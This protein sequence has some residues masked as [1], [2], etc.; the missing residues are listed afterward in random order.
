MWLQRFH[1]DTS[2]DEKIHFSDSVLA[3]SLADG[4][5]GYHLAR[6]T[7]DLDWEKGFHVPK[8]QS[9]QDALRHVIHLSAITR[10]FRKTLDVHGDFFHV[11][12]PSMTTLVCSDGLNDG[13][14]DLDRIYW[15]KRFQEAW[16]KTD[17]F[18]LLVQHG[19]GDIVAGPNRPTA[20][21]HTYTVAQK[22][23]LLQLGSLLYSHFDALCKLFDYEAVE[24]PLTHL[25]DRLSML[26][27]L[28][29]LKK[30]NVPHPT[31]PMAAFDRIFIEVNWTT[32]PL[33]DHAGR[34]MELGE[35]LEALIRVANVRYAIEED[36]PDLLERLRRLLDEKILPQALDLHADPFLRVWHSKKFVELLGHYSQYV[37]EYL[38]SQLR[39]ST[40]R[41]FVVAI[42]FVVLLS[43][44]R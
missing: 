43:S 33:P 44:G 21:A 29:L 2:L 31:I 41:L 37:A 25:N 5:K 9:G 11:P 15:S 6:L 10:A 4:D 19:D 26:S 22:K 17:I 38:L 42:I 39:W 27:F 16:D 34:A 28:H 18:D 32:D 23:L 12:H 7:G 13:E 24:D 20:E 36:H 8:G 3:G 1:A 14:V 35:F 40:H 30:C